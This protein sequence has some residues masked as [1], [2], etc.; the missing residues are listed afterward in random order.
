MKQTVFVISH[1]TTHLSGTD[2]K[3]RT[4]FVKISCKNIRP[5]MIIGVKR[6]E[7]NVFSV[8]IGIRRVFSEWECTYIPLLSVYKVNGDLECCVY[9]VYAYAYQKIKAIFVVL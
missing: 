7:E 3:Y 4:N 8:Y 5:I 1:I 6:T 9:C 2:T